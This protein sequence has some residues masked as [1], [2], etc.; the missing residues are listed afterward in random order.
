MLLTMLKA[1]IH[2]ATLTMTDLHYEGS[3]AIDEDILDA[4]G[5]LP[6]E[7]VAIWNIN[8]GERLETYALSAGRGSREF[9]LNGA[10][11]RRA[12]VG[13]KVIIAAYGQVPAEQARNYQP[14]VVLMG[15]NNRVEKRS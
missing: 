9:M 1:K 6:Y 11:A 4:A 3:I 13:D 10:A 12:A 2:R 7:K 8:N 5:I 14:T 15:E